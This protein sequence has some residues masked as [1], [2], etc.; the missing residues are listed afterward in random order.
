MSEGR[1]IP[2]AR[3]FAFEMALTGEEMARLAAHLDPAWPV[4]HDGPTASGAFGEAATT[5]TM[6]IG[7]A[8]ERAFGPIRLAVADVVLRIGS[9]DEAVVARLLRRF[10]LVFRKGGG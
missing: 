7:A 9:D 6:T 1:P 4:R 2:P 10:H 3:V 8:R 5:W